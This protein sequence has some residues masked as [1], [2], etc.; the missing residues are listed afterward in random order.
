[1]E[2]DTA[3]ESA[4]SES[5]FGYDAD[6][7]DLSGC[8]TKSCSSITLS[9]DSHGSVQPMRQNSIIFSD[10]IRCRSKR[11]KSSSRIFPK[12]SDSAILQEPNAMQLITLVHAYC[13]TQANHEQLQRHYL[14]ARGGGTEPSSDG[15]SSFFTSATEFSAQSSDSSGRRTTP[16]SG[17]TMQA[18]VKQ[19]SMARRQK[20]SH[21]GSSNDTLTLK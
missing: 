21:T 13:Q 14:R 17:T 16:S 12:P 4:G 11:K 6:E 10:E 7:D 9:E 15:F 3:V 2:Q 20:D 19:G 8:T 5:E 18:D 1:M